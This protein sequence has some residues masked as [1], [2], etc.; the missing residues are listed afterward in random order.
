MSKQ[1]PATEELNA[2]SGIGLFFAL[3]G[4]PKPERNAILDQMDDAAIRRYVHASLSA[5]AKYA[6]WIAGKWLLAAAVSISLLVAMYFAAS[7]LKLFILAA[8]G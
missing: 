4:L 8:V 3:N 1:V 2:M 7:G 5:N 6:A